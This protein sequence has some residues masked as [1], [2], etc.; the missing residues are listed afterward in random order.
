VLHLSKYFD[1]GKGLFHPHINTLRLSLAV[2]PVTHDTVSKKGVQDGE[3]DEK[4][5]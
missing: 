2:M 4:G 1:E 3:T 5:K